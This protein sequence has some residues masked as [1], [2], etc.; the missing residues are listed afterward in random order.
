MVEPRFRWTFAE[1][2]VP[3]E[4]VVAKPLELGLERHVSDVH[5]VREHV[6]ARPVE[7]G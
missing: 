2:L 7:L 3:S 6:H 5:P 4:A 1:E